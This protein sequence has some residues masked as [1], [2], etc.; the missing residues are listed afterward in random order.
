MNTQIIYTENV[1]LSYGVIHL[2]DKYKLK[3]KGKKQHKYILI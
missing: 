1:L 2:H 3:R